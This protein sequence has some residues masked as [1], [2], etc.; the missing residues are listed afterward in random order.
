MCP[1]GNLV[2]TNNSSVT[3]IIYNNP[4]P[5]PQAT[6]PLDNSFNDH[7]D[8]SKKLSCCF[9]F[10]SYKNIFF[11]ESKYSPKDYVKK[12][13]VDISKEKGISQ[14]IIFISPLLL[15][16]PTREF[17]KP[18]LF[19]KIDLQSQIMARLSTSI[20]ALIKWDPESKILHL[21]GLL[22]TEAN[23]EAKGYSKYKPYIKDEIFKILKGKKYKKT[24]RLLNWEL[25][26]DNLLEY[27][28]ID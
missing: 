3:L 7:T 18:I 2:L 23:F 28:L 11:P 26:F 21:G 6:S 4:F 13:I 9:V 16:I 10:R 19:D 15:Y 24:T 1:L 22:C 27:K 5:N 8:I 20:L 17:F 12:N 14:D 25:C